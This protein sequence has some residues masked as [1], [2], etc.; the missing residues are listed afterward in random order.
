MAGLH[1]EG[2]HQMMTQTPAMA[3]QFHMLP[4]TMESQQQ[5][6]P[7]HQMNQMAAMMSMAA[8][9]IMSCDGSTGV[10][11]MPSQTPPPAVP[12][13]FA[14]FLAAQQ[15]GQAP[16]V[17]PGA[18]P[19][20]AQAYAV[21]AQYLQQA[22]AYGGLCSD[23]GMAAAPFVAAPAPQPNY[24]PAPS[25]PAAISVAVEGVKFQYQLTDDDLMKVFSRYGAVHEINVDEVGTAAS[26]IFA[27]FSYAQAAMNDL[28]GKVLNGLEGT[29]RI[30]WAR[31][32]GMLA[33][34][35][36]SPYS[37]MPQYPAGWGFPGATSWPPAPTSGLGS[38]GDAPTFPQSPM[39]AA[40]H[41]FS[42]GPPGTPPPNNLNSS[43]IT[44]DGKAP[45]HVKG[46]RK[47]TCR[48][49]IGI[50][51]D[52]S[53][54]VVRRI[55]GAKGSNMKRIVKQSEAKLRLRGVGSGYFEGAGQK[56]SNE[57]L[58]LCVS[59]TSSDGYRTAVT[60]VEELLEGAYSEF[61]AFCKDNGRPEPDLHATP[62]LVSSGR[63]RLGGLFCSPDGG[64]SPGALAL[65]T[66]DDD[67]DELSPPK[68]EGGRKRGRRSRGKKSESG[69]VEKGEPPRNA[70]DLEEIQQSIDSRNE[71]RRQC[72]FSE[73]DRIRQSLH[74]RGVA[75]MDEP[76]GR[77]KASEVTTWRY[78]RE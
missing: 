11:S 19:A 9:G 16:A 55:I 58:Q 33:A 12:D 24:A 64:S 18:D 78:W 46:V 14:G 39:P 26:I 1:L 47:Y 7:Q 71:A 56:E 37:V 32:S 17:F 76:G 36:P 15:L 20:M 13:A 40:C 4:Q 73:A 3:Q 34:A 25:G 52:K 29:L 77:G 67:D 53:F 49:V 28:N 5:L 70:P 8:A 2:D 41:S 35:A 75:L 57:P 45:A 10:P 44:P 22:Q 59:C 72:N 6:E 62:Q 51:N 61:R 69:K 60:L 23:P 48:F 31:H 38:M 63:D 43:L 27:D 66:D 50:E 54:Q 65:D 21:M 74:E 42:P 68:R 30:T